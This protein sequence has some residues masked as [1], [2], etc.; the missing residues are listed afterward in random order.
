MPP[1]QRDDALGL[2]L[3]VLCAGL[4]TMVALATPVPAS[5][6]PTYLAMAREGV[7]DVD[8]WTWAAGEPFVNGSLGY[9][10]LIWGV[11]VVG[12]WPLVVGVH[13]AAIGAT[14]FGA[15][16]LGWRG[17]GGRGAAL[18]AL[19]TGALVLQNHAARPQTLAFPLG[20]VA[21]A[22]L[23]G[24]GRGRGKAAA[25]ALLLAL[26]AN[27]HGSFPVGL[28]LAAC[29]GLRPGRRW[30]LPAA[31][32]GCLCTPWG[33]SLF[34]YVAANS[35]VPAQRGLGEWGGPGLDPI[36]L[37]LWPALALAAWLGLRRRPTLGHWL[38]VLGL[39]VLALT[40][41]RH[42]A[43]FGL[44]AGPLV[45]GWIRPVT[46]APAR[47]LHRGVLVLA[48]GLVAVG[49][50]RFSP[51]IAGPPVPDRAGDNW[52]EARAPVEALDALAGAT[53]PRE[54]CVPFAMGGLVRW[55]L[56]RGWTVPVDVRVWL[57]DD[58]TW[59]QYRATRSE[60]ADCVLLI[61]RQREPHLQEA[62]ESWKE[63]Y[64]DQEWTLRVPG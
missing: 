3:A 13:G 33:L 47:R 21:V 20:V 8:A 36:G 39:G 17:A 46:S 1:L 4:L 2:A 49:L 31:L 62:T 64:R 19:M 63:L 56:G 16:G 30:E 53:P 51:W 27:V 60:A 7:W 54:V 59:E 55:R 9:Q 38:P 44:V 10:R 5:D 34:G 35:L 48:V 61:D 11:F 23:L 52:L 15:A 28:G 26:W 12:G 50:L 18:G 22:L 32:A 24:E 43:W 57:F 41:I 58:P 45:A 29:A 37:R 40:G 42:V 6:L 14:V 25:W